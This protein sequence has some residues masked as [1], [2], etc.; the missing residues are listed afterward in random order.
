MEDV[1][2]IEMSEF[3][4][5]YLE[6]IPGD[7][8]A[9]VDASNEEEYFK[10]N[11]EI[12]KTIPDYEKCVELSSIILKEKSKDVKV[13][14]WLCFALFRTEKIKGLKDGFNIINQLL[15]KYG[16]QLYPENDLHRSKALQF[17]NTARFFKLIERERIDESNAG[18][19][20]EAGEILAQIINESKKL[21][22]GNIPVLKSIKEAVEE[23]VEKAKLLTAPLPVREEN[24]PDEI[25]ETE[26]KI[27]PNITV[28]MPTE[29]YAAIDTAVPPEQMKL[30]VEKDALKQIRQALLFYFEKENNGIKKEQVP[31]TS[32]IFGLS[33]QL[34][35]GRLMKPPDTNKVTQIDAPNQVIQNKIK[36][37][38]AAEN[39]DTLIPRIEIEFL[40]P[41]SGFPYWL[42]AQRYITKALEKKGGLFVQASQEIKVNLAN[43]LKRLPELPQLIFKDKQTPFAGVETA[44]WIDDE[45]KPLLGG[46]SAGSIIM[47]PI[48]GEDYE[49]I[50]KQFE[51][52]CSELPDKFEENLDEM[53]KNIMTDDLK[54]GKFLRRLNL[55]NY[56]FA[57]KQYNISKINLTELSKLIDENNLTE[58]EPALCTAVWQSIFL[59]NAKIINDTD[60]EEYK[61]QIKKEQSELFSKIAK[62][63]GK[64]ALKLTNN[65]C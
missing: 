24:I 6:P 14:S 12:P 7:K 8:P 21:F 53:Q 46:G 5:E 23:H 28:E 54:K 55:S 22:K 65:K 1:K 17:L 56:C 10:L 3:V 32:F 43:L 61:S 15:I 37:W 18:D 36:E 63:N 26:E 2:E 57:A 52:A 11:M 42:E 31:E 38:F 45:V 4:R 50:A 13:A 51:A 33:R 59:T 39:W 58:W 48:M 9:G 27:I 29:T 25:K 19:I 44:K 49:P 40:K 64:L 20:I 47:P 16:N 35:W 41:D 30:T 62:Y 34:Q 60:D